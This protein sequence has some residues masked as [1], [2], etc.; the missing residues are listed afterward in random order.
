MIVLII[1]IIHSHVFE[2]VYY[3]DEFIG[4]I[5]SFLNNGQNLIFSLPNMEEMLKRKHTN[6]IN[7][8]HT[9]II[10]LTYV[11]FGETLHK[12]F[13]IID[14]HHIVADIGSDNKFTLKI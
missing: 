7:F 14:D 5:S 12:K 2:H 10:L 9:V 6:C 4:H 13:S 8:E 11:M 3:P 1:A